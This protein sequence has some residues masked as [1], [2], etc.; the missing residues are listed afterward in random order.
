VFNW[1]SVSKNEVG[2]QGFLSAASFPLS[3][4]R[5]LFK[6]WFEA[7]AWPVSA[8]EDYAFAPPATSVEKRF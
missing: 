7:L 2:V 4:R 1:L 8:A 5:R 6:S 3:S